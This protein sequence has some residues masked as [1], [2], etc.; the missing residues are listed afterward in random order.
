MTQRK[1]CNPHT[2][3]PAAT[4][5]SRASRN[6]TDESSKYPRPDQPQLSAGCMRSS[7][8]TCAGMSWVSLRLHA[9]GSAHPTC[10]CKGTA[11]KHALQG[12]SSQSRKRGGSSAV[13][14]KGRRGCLVP[15][16]PPGL[17]A[18]CVC[19]SEP[20]QQLKHVLRDLAAARSIRAHSQQDVPSP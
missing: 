11:I 3:H 9:K 1:R 18:G 4:L 19:V 6:S 5:R 15:R 8:A 13:F 16:A 2:S 12:V 10:T 20:P 14:R 7:A 17:L